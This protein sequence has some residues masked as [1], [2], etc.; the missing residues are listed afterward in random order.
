MISDQSCSRVEG[1]DRIEDTLPDC[2][3]KLD[4]E[5]RIELYLY[6]IRQCNAEWVMIKDMRGDKF[7]TAAQYAP[8]F[9]QIIPYA[10][11]MNLV[12][13]L[14]ALLSD[15]EESFAQYFKRLT[16]EKDR[17]FTRRFFSTWRDADTGEEHEQEWENALSFEQA[18]EM[19]HSKLVSLKKKQFEPLRNAR[20][21][22]YCHL[23]SISTN[24]EK[25]N[26]LYLNKLTNDLI[27]TTLSE[28]GY[29]IGTLY[30]L[31]SNIQPATKYA[32][33]NDIRGVFRIFEKYDKYKDKIL[34]LR[35][36]E[37]EKQLNNL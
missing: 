12:T 13:E 36:Q 9:W 1:K 26:E 24:I 21:K 27:D 31:Y 34:E 25:G 8:T 15:D 2:K 29:I 28:L 5:K 37:F 10:L 23:T 4:F 20:N 14:T 17:V 11:Q 33:Q 32:N 30:A 6:K 18:Y 7:Y 3:E 35:R 19:C 22:I 16:E